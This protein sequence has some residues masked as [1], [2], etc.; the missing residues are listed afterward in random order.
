[1]RYVKKY[2]LPI[3]K[4]KVL[5]HYPMRSS[6]GECE[7]VTI[8][9]DK[10]LQKSLK[11]F[12]QSCEEWSK[13][14]VEIVPTNSNRPLNPQEQLFRTVITD[15]FAVDKNYYEFLR[16]RLEITESVLWKRRYICLVLGL[17]CLNYMNL[18]TSATFVDERNM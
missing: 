14:I 18:T 1:M 3:L 17:P 15:K 7:V 2:L 4:K 5:L 13:L 11:I 12:Y 6:S 10:F 16:E 9:N 8:V